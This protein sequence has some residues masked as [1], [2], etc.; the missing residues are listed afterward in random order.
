M[1]TSP[2]VCRRTT[3]RN[4]NTFSCYDAIESLLVESL[5]GQHRYALTLLVYRKLSKRMRDAV[6]DAVD[7]WCHNYSLLQERLV[8]TTLNRDASGANEL[9][10][11][12]MV[13]LEKLVRCAFGSCKGS[14]QNVMYVSKMDSAVYFGAS[15]KRCVLCGCKMVDAFVVEDAEDP[16][17]TPFYTFAHRTCQ[18]KHMVHISDRPADASAPRG[19][20]A[21]LHREVVALSKMIKDAKTR[22]AHLSFDSLE[23]SRLFYRMSNWY[24]T[25]AASSKPDLTATN[26][27]S[28]SMIVW[29]RPHERVNM[30]D[31]VC[32][33]L[34]VTSELIKDALRHEEQQKSKLRE[35]TLARRLSVQKK[36]EE[37][38]GAYEADIILWLGKGK[39][40]WRSL[41][42]LL[43][44]HESI[45]HSSC[46]DRLI[47]PSVKRKEKLTV[48][49]VC[50]S[51]QIFSRTI[52]YMEGGMASATMDWVVRCAKVHDMFGELG[53]EMQYIDSDQ[54]ELAVSN[55]ASSHAKV[56]GMM[57]NLT[58]DS[59]MEVKVSSLPGGHAFGKGNVD[60]NVK[61]LMAE[62]LVISSH[63]SMSDDDIGKFK[64]A[65][66]AKL[67]N[68]VCLPNIPC[69]H[70]NKD[71]NPAM[72]A[73]R[74]AEFLQK[75]LKACFCKNA[76]MARAVGLEL[77]FSLDTFQNILTSFDARPYT[78]NIKD[79]NER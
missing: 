50:Y 28:H 61:L 78:D 31:T 21:E 17:H 72:H 54:V 37:L 12:T 70:H 59:V 73:E 14:M 65:A 9:R 53:W 42:D 36:T 20:S 58:P 74:V 57:Q 75:I 6:D 71:E 56:L 38:A 8:W 26:Q 32:G 3:G 29:F 67:P 48:A 76:G 34:G 19:D 11:E 16:R 15:S 24:W 30:K 47:N 46:I 13:S 10:F 35:M 63:F 45:M 5:V 2:S 41:R 77:I 49:S 69:A 7:R 4:Q 22:P 66:A 1:N 40:R 52:D 64:Y 51:L 55:E 18:R 79:L 39:T 23:F 27:R 62:G 25:V 43:C 44:V 60:L 68:R 33:A